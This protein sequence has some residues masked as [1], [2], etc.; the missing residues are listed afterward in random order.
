LK[1]GTTTKLNKLKFIL[2][3]YSNVVNFFIDKFWENTPSKAQL[4]KPIVDLPKTWLSA[5]LRKVAAREAIDMILSSKNKEDEKARTFK[6]RH[7]GKSMNVSS[8]IVSLQISKTNAYDC[9]LHIASV[10]NGIILDL[11]IKLHKHFNQLK[12]KGKRLESFIIKEDCVQFCFEIETGAKKEEGRVIGVDSGI[13]AL[14]STSEGCQYGKDIK[15]LV[16]KVKRKQHGSNAQKRTRRALKQRMNEVAKEVIQDNV[17]LV[18][19]EDLK[20]MNHNTKVKRR[21]TKNMRRSLG[22]WVYRYWLNR[23]S[24]ACEDNRVAY[25]K[26]CPAYTSQRCNACGHIERGNR[27]GEMFLCQKCGHVDNAD[28]N[29]AKNIEFRYTSRPYGAASKPEK[30]FI[31]PIG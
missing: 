31:L 26:V 8:T 23:I 11:P 10:G 22:A 24:M 5:R 2:A 19:V 25:R 28:I 9:W 7:Y 3:E 14:A 29:A 17:K 15:G 21:L 13:N 20:K 6:P 16:E 27:N 12:L 4:L 18:V 30:Y 1:F